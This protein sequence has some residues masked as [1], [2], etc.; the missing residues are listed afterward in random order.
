MVFRLLIVA[1]VVLAVG[2][3]VVPARGGVVMDNLIMSFDGWSDP[4]GLDG[5]TGLCTIWPEM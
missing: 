4:D 5:W 2:L 3:L 1:A